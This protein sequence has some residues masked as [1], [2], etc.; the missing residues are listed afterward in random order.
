MKLSLFL[1]SN[2][3]TFGKGT[4]WLNNSFFPFSFSLSCYPVPFPKVKK[5]LRNSQLAKKKEVT[6]NEKVCVQ[7]EGK[8]PKFQSSLIWCGKAV[9][10]KRE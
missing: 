8:P 3:F 5:D 7:A 9:Q 1:L 4:E 10:L 2:I 6:E